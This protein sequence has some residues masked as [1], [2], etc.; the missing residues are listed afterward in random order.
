[1]NRQA[2]APFHFSVS[3]RPEHE[4]SFLFIQ[5]RVMYADRKQVCI[6][7][8]RFISGNELHLQTLQSNCSNSS[9]SQLENPTSPSCD[10][11]LYTFTIPLIAGDICKSYARYRPTL[12]GYSMTL[13]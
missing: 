8:K 12:N 11:M 9:N 5:K 10:Q 13:G 2:D 1:M 4:V 7:I 3:R 6:K